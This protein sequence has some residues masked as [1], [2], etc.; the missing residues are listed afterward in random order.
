M[1][2]L[3]GLVLHTQNM[4]YHNLIC[5]PACK[6]FKMKT[7]R[8]TSPSQT[9]HCKK[10]D[11]EPQGSPPSKCCDHHWMDFIMTKQSMFGACGTRTKN[12]LIDLVASC[13]E[14]TQ[15][16]TWQSLKRHTVLKEYKS[17]GIIHSVAKS[18][19]TQAKPFAL[20]CLLADVC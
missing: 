11:D 7:K 16:L 9:S 20:P 5:C 17:W 1:C 15:T 12:T 14:S 19:I 4:L 6:D 3:A 2:T 10:W 8:V 18:T 13:L